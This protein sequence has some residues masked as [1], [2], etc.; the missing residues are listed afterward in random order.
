MNKYLLILFILHTF[1]KGIVGSSYPMTRESITPP[2]PFNEGNVMERVNYMSKKLTNDEFITKAHEKHFS[3]YDYSNVKY[4]DSNTPVCII[5]KL[6]GEFW[7]KPNIHL[8]G[9]GCP[10]CGISNRNKRN[11]LHSADVIIRMKETHN[12]FYSYDKFIYVGMH[13]KGII[14]CPIHGDFLQ[15]AHEHLKGNGCPSC[16]KKKK[17][18]AH[19]FYIIAHEKF[20]DKFSYSNDFKNAHTD[21]EIYCPTHG[22]FTMKPYNHLR[23]KFGCPTC[24]RDYLSKRQKMD[25]DTFVNRAKIVHEDEFDYSLVNDNNFIDSKT[26][27]PIICQKHGVFFQK[28][29]NH[30]SGAK[31]PCCLRSKGEEVISRYLNSHGIHFLPQ[32]K[33]KNESVLSSVKFFRVDFYIQQLNV[34]IEYNGQQHYKNVSIF[35]QRT[36]DEQ[37][38]RDTALRIYCSTNHIKLIEIPYNE[39]KNIEEILNTKLKI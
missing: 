34:I 10:V 30:L 5:C 18:T 28:P 6:H 23:S 13:K 1:A 2:F 25:K 32:Y 15:S 29:N 24:F 9:S 16:S 7:Q 14:T 4:I 31:C 22:A 37:R 39:I 38:A 27:I 21:I 26:K 36:L 20:G 19:D 8:C 33:I 17:L 12:G 11:T 35:S 3:K